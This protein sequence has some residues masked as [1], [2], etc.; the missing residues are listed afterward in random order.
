MLLVMIER[1]TTNIFWQGFAKG[2]V[3]GGGTAKQKTDK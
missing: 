3:G 1:D 2:R